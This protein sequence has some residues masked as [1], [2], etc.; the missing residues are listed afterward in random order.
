MC[1]GNPGPHNFA[2]IGAGFVPK[3]LKVSLIDEVIR[4]GHDQAEE[5]VRTLAIRFGIYAG[6]S[7]GAAYSAALEQA[8]KF[9]PEKIVLTI[10][11]DAGERYV[12]FL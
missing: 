9:G 5:A 11:C 1:G 8:S 2:G 12:P 7:S 3:N 6:L 10:I 4:V